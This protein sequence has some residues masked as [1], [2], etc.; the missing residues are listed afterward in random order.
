M[1]S[2]STAVCRPT[3]KVRKT[4]MCIIVSWKRPKYHFDV[5]IDYHEVQ[6]KAE[7][8]SLKEEEGKPPEWKTIMHGER[9]AGNET[10]ADDLL[11]TVAYFFRPAVSCCVFVPPPFR[12]K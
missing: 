6:A 1:R 7:E 3:T 2:A 4:D 5:P 11:P 8:G 9:V 12:V 10:L